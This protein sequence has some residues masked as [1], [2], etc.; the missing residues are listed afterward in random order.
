MRIKPY[1]EENKYFF[2]LLA[3][4]EAPLDFL[5]TSLTLLRVHPHEFH[6]RSLGSA[7]IN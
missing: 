7:N 6:T 5:K 4:P 1:L 2:L 3:V